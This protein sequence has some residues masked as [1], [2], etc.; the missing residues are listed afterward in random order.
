MTLWPAAAQP[1]AISKPVNVPVPCR[2]TSGGPVPIESTTVLT[3]LMSWAARS[4]PVMLKGG[5]VS[6]TLIA[7]SNARPRSSDH[8]EDRPLRVGARQAEQRPAG[9]L[10]D[11]IGHQDVLGAGMDVA[12][13]ALHRRV[14]QRG[15]ARR[16]M[17]KGADIG[18][19]VVQVA[20]AELDHGH[21]LERRLLAAGKAV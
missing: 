3:P 8:S 4:K 10:D 11:L 1:R 20:K 13:E 16:A 15:A 21:L 17:R 12:V 2:K 14:V 5:F 18:N 9:F 19:D 7:S 6:A